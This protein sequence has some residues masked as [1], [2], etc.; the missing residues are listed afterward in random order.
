MFTFVGFGVAAALTIRVV[1]SHVEAGEQPYPGAL[2][3]NVQVP[4]VVATPTFVDPEEDFDP[5]KEKGDP[6]GEILASQPPDETDQLICGFSPTVIVFDPAAETCELFCRSTNVIKINKVKY[7]L[8]Y[9]IQCTL[10]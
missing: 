9:S 10:Y 5:E 8:I 3:L 2:Q 6:P 1:E 4:G 7:F